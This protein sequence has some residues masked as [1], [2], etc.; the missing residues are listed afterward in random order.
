MQPSKQASNKPA[1][2]INL[3]KK[4]IR[5]IFLSL[6]FLFL[7]L[8]IGRLTYGYIKAESE[9]IDFSDSGFDFGKRNFASYS[10]YSGKNEPKS[11]EYLT[12]DGGDSKDF[13]KA[14]PEHLAISEIRNEQKYEKIGSMSS[15]SKQF[16]VDEKKVYQIVKENNGIIQYELKRGLIGKRKFQ[17]AIGVIPDKFDV[18][19]NELK[20][21]GK[22]SE[23]VVTKIDKTTEFRGLNAKKISLIK[24]RTSLEELKNKQ[25]TLADLISLQEKIREIEAKIQEMGVE[26]GSFSDINDY[27]TIKVSLSEGGNSSNNPTISGRIIVALYWAVEYYFYIIFISI[28]ALITGLIALVLMVEAIKYW[29]KQDT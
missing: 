25:G 24:H 20:K 26:L 15:S 10:D 1:T 28:G 27:C 19:L 12:V 14:D 3:I 6:I 8:F 21:I 17:I 18:T 7:V 5:K 23:F 2:R 29:N 16:D 22:L 11:K 9:I 13:S 4:Y